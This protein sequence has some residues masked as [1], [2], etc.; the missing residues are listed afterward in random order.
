VSLGAD[1]QPDGF[2]AEQT[3]QATGGINTPPDTPRPSNRARRGERSA[4]RQSAL[5]ERLL[6]VNE[7]AAMLGVQPT[8]LYKWA[9]ERRLPIVKLF[10]LRGALRFRLS[11]IEKLIAA[12]D[13]PA[14]RGF[15]IDS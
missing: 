14:L 11:A 15:G 4:R 9:H 3:R 5:P 6:D 13:Q 1:I 2:D 12:S 8:T 10:G 7:A